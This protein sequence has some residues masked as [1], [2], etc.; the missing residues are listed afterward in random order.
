M[1][2]TLT[3]VLL[4]SLVLIPASPAAAGTLTT[5]NACLWS[6]DSLWRD[7]AVDLTGT[8]APNPVAPASGVS[9]TASSVHAR[10][11][12][13]VGSI[14]ANTGLLKPGE[15][16]IPTKV[17]VALAG[18]GLTPGVQVLR[19]RDDRSHDRDRASRRD[20]HVDADRRHDPAARHGVGHG[21]RGHRRVEAGRPGHAAE[22]SRRQRRRER[23]AE[24]QRVHLVHVRGRRRASARLPAGDRAARRQVVHGRARFAVRVRPGQGRRAGDAAAVGQEAR[25][26]A[27]DD[28]AL[29]QAASASRSP[30]PLRRARAR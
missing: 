1:R 13:W 18:D 21:G 26:R 2:W 28:E 11:P 10:L 23:R 9:L 5:T 3:A 12:D 19:A 29:R 25:R 22:R 8:G 14:G 17:W 16:E 24:G 20:L 27:E 30:A 15:N 6:I 7:Q 4:A